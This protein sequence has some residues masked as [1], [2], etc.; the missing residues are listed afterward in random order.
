MINQYEC[1]KKLDQ[2]QVL[3]PFITNLVATV[4]FSCEFDLQRIAQG[5][6]NAK[7][8]PHIFPFLRLSIDEPKAMA[9]IYP[10]GK[11]NILRAKNPDE[12]YIVAR[13]IMKI[14]SKITTLK[15][16]NSK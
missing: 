12:A 11:V 6:K 7:Y 5:L 9:I 16:K 10:H 2:S 15:S 13:R 8:N 4:N 1:N 3:K 14:L